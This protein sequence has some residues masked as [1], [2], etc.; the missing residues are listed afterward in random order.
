MAID[1]T[2]VTVE[3]TPEALTGAAATR[4]GGAEIPEAR[5]APS[6][7]TTV[8]PTAGA[9]AGGVM[10]ASPQLRTAG[11]GLGLLARGAGALSSR[12]PQIFAP[13]VPSL[14]GS[15][16]GTVAGTA[17]ER[18]IEGDLATAEGAKQLLGNVAENAVWDLG[19]N[20]A[21]RAGGKV[22]RL[23]KDTLGFGKTEIPDAAAAAQKFL[24]E[25]GATLTRGQ[26][27]EG[28]TENIIESAVR[29][30]AGS[31]FFKAQ[32][33]G[34]QKA[35]EQGKRELLESLDTSSAFKQALNSSDDPSYAAGSIF[36]NA[37]TE[38]EKE[39]K[40]KTTPFYQSLDE[41]SQGIMVDFK[42]AKKQAQERLSSM[43]LKGN[44]YDAKEIQ[45]LEDIAAQDD[46]LK[47]SDAH[48][49]RSR[50]LTKARD[51]K[52]AAE[53]STAAEQAYNQ[54]GSVIEK[55][56]DNAF[57]AV[58]DLSGYSKR[59]VK[60]PNRQ[61]A[62]AL[63]AEYDANRQLYREGIDAIYNET[64]S[65]LLKESSNPERIG[66]ILY[67]SGNVTELKDLYKTA[68]KL[69]NLGVKDAFGK[70]ITS[71]N[72]IDNLR[73][74]YINSFM[75]NPEEIAMFGQK[76]ADDAA[77]ERTYKQLFDPEQ[78]NFIDTMTNAAARGLTDVGER[79][80]ALRTRQ[81]G[82]AANLGT[83]VG[84][85]LAAGVGAGAIY[86]LPPEAQQR[87]SE[88]LPETVAAGMAGLG[89]LIVT[90]RLMA[91]AMTNKQVMDALTGIAKAQQSPAYGGA[92]TAKIIDRLNKLGVFDSEYI[93]E[94][95]K[96]F[97]RPPEQQVAEEEQ[98]QSY[99]P[100]D[101][102]QV[103]VAQ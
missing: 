10:A 35:V 67:R 2:K 48:D 74:G 28:A 84:R 4:F 61:A 100:I 73:Y 88:N 33:A 45:A 94:V 54:F 29:E 24:S 92:I 57:N 23:A 5:F 80:T 87:L 1:W 36:K 47:F 13:Y 76:V 71:K 62:M 32:Q 65:K 69:Q 59:L 39:L 15:T 16:V 53:P 12:V 14:F 42:D 31:P 85:A 51:M 46:Y 20:L 38:G 86:S 19:G 3:T 90:P 103:Q 83:N 55:S 63:K 44:V 98:Q 99:G 75:R 52:N 49:L 22:Y 30:G 7:E 77:F 8:L 81:V 60:D 66:E 102:N 72:L 41:K 93:S 95:D 64:M 11:L 50:Y 101:W 27:T 43:Q 78:R 34:V 82:F 21:F 56:M 89:A 25:R 91:K 70:P 37:L 26:L 40:A 18:A 9:I 96:F 6:M 58:L 17:A 97:N 68:A 79:T